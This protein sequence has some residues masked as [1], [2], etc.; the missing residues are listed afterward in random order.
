MNVVLVEDSPV[1]RDILVGN[2]SLIQD[3]HVVGHATTENE[4]MDVLQRARP[5]LAIVDLEL[6][7]GSGMGVLQTVQQ[8]PEQYGSPTLIVFSNHAHPG[9]RRRCQVL[10]ASAFFDK[11]FQMDELFD[12]IKNM[13]KNRCL[14]SDI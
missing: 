6:A 4:A 12:Y 3:I 8:S 13:H 7:A 10:G 11:A 9:I 2:L 14:P 5:D 1:L